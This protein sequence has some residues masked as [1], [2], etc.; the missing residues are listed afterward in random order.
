MRRTLASPSTPQLRCPLLRGHTSEGP[1]AFSPRVAAAW[2][3]PG[4]HVHQSLLWQTSKMLTDSVASVNFG[5]EQCP[6]Y[7]RPS[8]GRPVIS[9][10]VENAP[11]FGDI[12]APA[13]STRW[14]YMPDST[15]PAATNFRTLALAP[16]YINAMFFCPSQLPDVRGTCTFQCHA[17]VV[18]LQPRSVLFKVAQAHRQS[19]RIVLS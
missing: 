7:A 19:W 17:G 8:M 10:R 4:T 18:I 9:Q 12:I 11:P 14:C 2:H 13:R 3:V 15:S 16:V 1:A 6:V 5:D